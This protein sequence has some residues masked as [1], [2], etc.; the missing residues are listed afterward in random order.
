MS[1]LQSRGSEQFGKVVNHQCDFEL[2]KRVQ[3]LQDPNAT[4]NND[5]KRIVVADL[6]SDTQDVFHVSG[7]WK[8]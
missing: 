7:L 3:G 1:S 4:I 8:T 6:C 2:L 5:L